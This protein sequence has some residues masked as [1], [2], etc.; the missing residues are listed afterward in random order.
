MIYKKLRL[1]LG[2]QLNAQHSW[3]KQKNED[4]LYL[5]AE[6]KQE[7]VYT[8]HHI[9]K[10]VAFFCA[11]E[12]FAIGLE[13]A[14]YNVLHL[15][16]DDTATYPDLPSLLMDIISQYKITCFEYQLPDEHRLREQLY[17]FCQSTEIHSHAFESEH[18]F[19]R[20]DELYQFFKAGKSHRLENFYR[21][22][23]KQFHILMNDDE[24]LG[25]KWNYDAANRNKLK[26]DD[27][28][29]IP[30]PMVFDNNI[31]HIV[32]RLNKHKIKSIGTIG[33][34]LLW[35]VTRSQANELLIFFCQ[36]CLKHFGT[37]Q[38]AMT[39]K[40][41]HLDQDSGWSLYHSRIAF[42]LNT[43]MLSPDH[44]IQT[45]I[46]YYERSE[47]EISI[48]QI[49]GFV[50]QIIGWREFVRGIYWA[51]MP[52]YAT[53]NFLNAKNSLPN[54]F[55][56]GDTKMHCLA[57]AISQS[58]NFSY[59]HH[60]QR[61]MVTGNFCLI[62]GIDPDQVEQWYLGIYIDAIEWVEMPNTR[63]MSL[64][65]DGGLLATKPYA[66]SGNYTKKMS[67]YC[68]SCQ[69]QVNETITE[70]ACPLNALYWHF[71]HTHSERFATNPRTKMVYANWYRKDETQQNAIL[72]KA[73]SILKKLDAL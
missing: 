72:A 10:I 71:M 69:Y 12:Q 40:L 13:K 67:D 30:M 4:T 15:T 49:E 55:W 33:S 29:E 1:V 63:G 14:G 53:L 21:K 18:F 50:R 38:D 9:Q 31:K 23:R 32:H 65:A 44:V 5:I 42:A 3:Y 25:G 19:L 47:G 56:N 59:A 62:A 2:D 52:N 48:A 64:F 54:W 41:V 27:L 43:K 51:N 36:V 24:P 28:A 6:L 37:F 70:N 46:Y 22:M 66:A 57:H 34:A 68:S 20:D 58:L 7:A 39:G 73:A 45:A 35:P 26:N 61:L 11:M 60:I 16:L 8:T 17:N